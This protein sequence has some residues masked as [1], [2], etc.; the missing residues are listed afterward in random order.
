MAAKRRMGSIPCVELG[1][2]VINKFREAAASASPA[3]PPLYTRIGYL[4]SHSSLPPLVLPRPFFSI[5]LLRNNCMA[6]IV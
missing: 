4:F 2:H 5:L 3:P 1:T 6:L